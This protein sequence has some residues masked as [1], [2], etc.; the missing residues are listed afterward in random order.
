LLIDHYKYYTAIFYYYKDIL[1]ILLIYILHF[2]S[3]Q[4]ILWI[5]IIFPLCR[6]LPIHQHI[7]RKAICLRLSLLLHDYCL[8]GCVV[9]FPTESR[10]ESPPRIFPISRRFSAFPHHL[11]HT[12]FQ[13]PHCVC[14]S[15]LAVYLTCLLVGLRQPVH[16]QSG[17]GISRRGW[18]T[19]QATKH[20]SIHTPLCAERGGKKGCEWVLG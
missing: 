4:S 16:R 19:K 12:F 8:F 17:V 1:S 6:H 13:Q 2:L 9:C 7:H 11:C 14:E 3:L 20:V 15:V 10:L 18:Q 5:W